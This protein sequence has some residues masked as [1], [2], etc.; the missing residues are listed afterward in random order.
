[1]FG[2]P[3]DPYFTLVATLTILGVVGA[4]VPST[5]P[6][7]DWLITGL[8]MVGSFSL[9]FIMIEA[10]NIFT[11]IPHF[12]QHALAYFI[13]VGFFWIVTACPSFNP[14]R[15]LG[16]LLW[17]VGS[18][19]FLW[20]AVQFVVHPYVFPATTL[21][22]FLFALVFCVAGFAIVMKVKGA[23]LLQPA[24][25]AG[26]ACELFTGLWGT[27]GLPVTN[28]ALGD[29]VYFL[30]PMVNFIECG[31]I[32]MYCSIMTVAYFYVARNPN[33]RPVKMA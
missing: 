19:E 18:H 13:F 28:T 20:N 22:W 30:N 8:M 21:N 9:L 31:E 3:F 5:R 25:A 17:A 4:Y 7:L 1:M 16:W 32:L 12:D 23:S 10:G 15:G 11:R 33:E 2:W 27:I 26:I 29:T 24:L 6:L 14:V